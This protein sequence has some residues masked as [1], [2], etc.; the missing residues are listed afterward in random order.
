MA[1]VVALPGGPEPDDIIGLK[2]NNLDCVIGKSIN[3]TESSQYCNTASS[4]YPC[5]INYLKAYSAQNIAVSCGRDL[6]L[7]HLLQVL[8]SGMGAEFGGVDVCSVIAGLARAKT[9]PD[10]N[11]WTD[12]GSRPKHSR[13]VSIIAEYTFYTHSKLHLSHRFIT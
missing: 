12:P 4:L 9:R 7:S 5:Q 6:Y 2:I 8:K 11:H 1:Q 13:P 10:R 3:S